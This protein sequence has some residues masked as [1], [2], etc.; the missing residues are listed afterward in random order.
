MLAGVLV[1]MGLDPVLHVS[2]VYGVPWVALIS[3]AYF[4]RRGKMRAAA[5]DA[6]ADAGLQ[7]GHEATTRKGGG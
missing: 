2:W 4:L 1:T 6:A 3:L 5:G 7:V